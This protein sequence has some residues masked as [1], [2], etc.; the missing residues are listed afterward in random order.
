MKQVWIILRNAD[1]NEGRGPMVFDAACLSEADARSYLN[2]KDRGVFG[3][4]PDGGKTFYDWVVD[5]GW[6][7]TGY[8]VRVVRATS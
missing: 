5:N 8:E 7:W 6:G 4:K 3:A 1:F 2:K